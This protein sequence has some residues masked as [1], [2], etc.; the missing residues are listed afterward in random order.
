MQKRIEPR[1][2]GKRTGGKE[3]AQGRGARRRLAQL[4]VCAALLAVVL[5]G[6]GLAPEK[7]AQSG[8]DLLDM[9]QTDADFQSAFAS[10]GQSIAQGEPVWTSLGELAREVFGAQTEEKAVLFWNSGPAVQ[11]ALAY[12]RAGG[13][14]LSVLGQ[15]NA[16]AESAALAALPEDAVM[17]YV[18]LDLEET[19]T[20]VFGAVTSSFGY[21]ADPATG[22]R[23]F[24]YG[25]DIAAEEGAP[26]L[27][28]AAG[29]VTAAGEDETSGLYLRL[30]HENQVETFYCHCSALYVQTGDEVAAGQAIAAVGQT[31][32]AT[33]PHLHFAIQ[34]GG[35]HLDP[36]Y[37]IETAC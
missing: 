18:E 8:Q 30:E 23:R 1:R 37:Y 15:L 14:P 33:G 35:V 29:T 27:A 13:D 16:G 25:A 24:H 22:A 19:A 3:S 36:E 20:P 2:R 26:I 28:F 9:M 32:N 34:C 10:L 31:G 5:A 17:D 7:L 21:R 4:L 11:A 12:M 6:K